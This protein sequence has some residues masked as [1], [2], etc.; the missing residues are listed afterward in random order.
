MRSTTMGISSM[1][2]NEQ[3]R[4]WS[5]EQW[6]RKASDSLSN[7][8]PT[9]A[10]LNFEVTKGGV[11]QPIDKARSI[12]QKMEDILHARGIKDPNK[13]ESVRRR[14]RTLA[15]FIF[16]GNRER[17]HELAFGSQKVDLSKNADNSSIVR[18]KDIENW[19]VDVYN[20]VA[21]RYGED[22]IVSFYVHLDEMNPHVHC[23]LLPIGERNRISW[24]DVFGK[25][26]YEESQSMRKLHDD[27][28]DEVNSKWGLT[29]GSNKEE[30]KARHRSTEEYRWN[31]INEVMVLEQTREGLLGQIKTAE[32][33]LKSLT[34]MMGN[35]QT[36][37]EAVQAEIDL[38]AEQFG[39]ESTDRADLVLQLRE[40]RKEMQG[41]DAKIELRQ[42]M[43][44]Q[45]TRLLET[46][47]S[48]LAELNR[49]HTRLQGK[50][51]DDYDAQATQH[52]R[53][54]LSA[55]VQAVDSSLQPVL[56]TLSPQQQQ[57]LERSGFYDLTDKPSDVMNCAL[58]LGIQFIHE[59]TNYAESC[60]GGGGSMTGWGRD[61]DDDDD[62]W[63]LKCVT[64]AAHMV[65]PAGRKMRRNR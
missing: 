12:G 20:F 33:K 44:E 10:S 30:T 22:N 51:G 18:S 59:A 11:V 1:E 43:L 50:V 57:V 24:V 26:R 23:T 4:N 25:N 29:R 65:K 14:Q 37:K 52:E 31:L 56:P 15:Q 21:R 47:R 6:R 9:R 46:A 17:M 62:R 38:I 39:Q 55:Y 2:S 54:M 34:T 40:L 32:R 53:N 64:K 60:G 48:R 42:Q 41:I 19:A 35:L 13:R 28:V 58:L 45:T 36:R 27:L 5:D 49:E 16:G 63:W 8:D 3:Q 7:Y 61:K